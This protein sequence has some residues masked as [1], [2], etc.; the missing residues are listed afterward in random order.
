MTEED[1]PARHRVGRGKLPTAPR[2]PGSSQQGIAYIPFTR[3][4]HF[5]TGIGFQLSVR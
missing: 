4:F 1:S 3:L 5:G 2:R